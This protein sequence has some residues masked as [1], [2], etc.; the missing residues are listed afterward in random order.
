[1]K[2]RSPAYYEDTQPVPCAG[3]PQI[4]DI[5]FVAPLIDSGRVAP[6]SSAGGGVKTRPTRPPGVSFTT[7]ETDAIDDSALL[8]V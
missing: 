6:P 5:A 4:H 1:M 7:N 2:K 3:A 8:A